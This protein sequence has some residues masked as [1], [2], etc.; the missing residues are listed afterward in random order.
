[1]RELKGLAEDANVDLQEIDNTISIIR[2]EMEED[3]KIR[4]FATVK[5]KRKALNHFQNASK[6]LFMDTFVSSFVHYCF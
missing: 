6:N 2:K 1:M 5:D 3:R 4:R